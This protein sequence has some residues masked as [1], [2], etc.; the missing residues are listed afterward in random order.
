MP[1]ISL[2]DVSA[3]RIDVWLAIGIPLIGSIAEVCQPASKLTKRIKENIDAMLL[4]GSAH[5]RG[6][7]HK[8]SKNSL[9]VTQ[10]EQRPD[11][12]GSSSTPYTQPQATMDSQAVDHSQ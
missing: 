12:Q 11:D 10:Q 8:K 4:S 2:Q 6:T 9:R 1:L 5:S 7:G 3:E